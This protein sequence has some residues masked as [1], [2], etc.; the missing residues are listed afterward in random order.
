MAKGP[1]M[2]FL[3]ARL[4]MTAANTFAQIQIPTPTSK[5]ENMAMLIHQIEFEPSIQVD[6][7]PTDGDSITVH[8]AKVS[9]SAPSGI[10]E[11]D[12]LAYLHIMTN[13]AAIFHALTVT[14]APLHKFDPP[15]LYPHANLYGG[16]TTVGFTAACAATF[17]IGYTL[18]KVS[19]EDFISALVE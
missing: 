10:H 3:R 15:I 9:K 19:R 8:L 14:G 16:V 2:E 4:V 7:V 11:P 17:R 6:S 1:F 12:S 13:L 5:T 18:E